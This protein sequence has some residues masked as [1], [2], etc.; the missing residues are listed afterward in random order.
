MVTGSKGEDYLAQ[1]LALLPTF[2]S[3]FGEHNHNQW[4]RP[5][6]RRYTTA[7]HGACL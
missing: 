7:L 4:I 2:H 5:D 3:T 6:R 1:D